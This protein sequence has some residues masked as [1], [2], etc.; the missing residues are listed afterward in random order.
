L[1]LAAL[2]SRDRDVYEALRQQLP[3]RRGDLRGGRH[4]HGPVMA[5]Y[6]DEEAFNEVSAYF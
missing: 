6:L 4:R 2:G 3:G 1:G 5:G